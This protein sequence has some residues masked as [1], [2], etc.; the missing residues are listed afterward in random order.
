MLAILAIFVSVSSLF[1]RRIIQHCSL[2][3]KFSNIW[4]AK[5]SILSFVSLDK[6]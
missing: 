6:T 5:Q 4:T 1:S 2:E 3:V